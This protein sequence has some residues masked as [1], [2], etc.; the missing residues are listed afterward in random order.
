VQ[1]DK[2]GFIASSTKAHL[3]R[4]DIR[5]LGCTP[6]IY[7]NAFGKRAA[8]TFIGLCCAMYGESAGLELGIRFSVML[9]ASQTADADRGSFVSSVTERLVGRARLGQAQFDP[10][11]VT[12]MKAFDKDGDF[13]AVVNVFCK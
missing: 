6:D 12:A 3:W 11:I 9:N 5:R 10:A 7:I 2:D 8:R 4:G 1:A 13:G